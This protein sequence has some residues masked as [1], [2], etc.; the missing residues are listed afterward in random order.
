MLGLSFQVVEMLPLLCLLLWTFV[1]R[2][3]CPMK[4]IVIGLQEFAD[5]KFDYLIVG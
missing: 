5:I 2:K 3:S 1:D 4:D